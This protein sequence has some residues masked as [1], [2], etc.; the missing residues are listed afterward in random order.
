MFSVSVE[1]VVVP[2]EVGMMAAQ[3]VAVDIP[4]PRM[5]WRWWLDKATKS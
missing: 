1:A 3:V 4:L 2:A 5:M